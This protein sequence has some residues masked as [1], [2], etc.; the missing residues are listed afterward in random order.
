MITVR[1][2]YDDFKDTPEGVPVVLVGYSADD[3]TTYQ[4]IKTDKAGRA[5]FT[6]L[7]RSGGTSYFAMTLL[8]RNGAVDRVMSLPVVLESQVGVRMILSSEKRDSKAPPIDDLNKADPQVATPAGKV[9][10]VLE[11][12]ADLTATV[13]LVDASTKKLIG[14]AK[15]ET[16]GPDPSR[17]QG[18]AQFDGRREAARRDARRR[19][20]RRSGADRRAAQGHRDPA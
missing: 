14:E 6:D 12:V 4:V 11:G 15:P 20:P 10:V 9:R 8:P 18:G 1:V 19:G 7:D 5:Q 3:T 17:V 13:R 16:S 2:T